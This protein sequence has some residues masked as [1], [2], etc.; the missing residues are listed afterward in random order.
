MAEENIDRKTKRDARLAKKERRQSK[1]SQVQDTPQGDLPNIELDKEK[2]G[3]LSSKQDLG[4]TPPPI[5]ATP[6][7]APKVTPKKE[8]N[9][10]SDNLTPPKSPPNVEDFGSKADYGDQDFSD[11]K[12]IADDI[13]KRRDY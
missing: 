10:L 7:V 8:S 11:P 5:E 12:R 9:V 1:K 6:K 3:D 13:F 2:L 4:A